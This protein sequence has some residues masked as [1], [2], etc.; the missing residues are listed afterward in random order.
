MRER[1]LDGR[2]GARRL[3]DFAAAA[4]AAGVPV[5]TWPNETTA[6]IL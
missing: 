5:A 2:L 4:V 3:A 1:V 6:P